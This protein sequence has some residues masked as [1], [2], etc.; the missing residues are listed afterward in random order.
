M[1]TGIPQSSLYSLILFLFYIAELHDL[2]DAPALNVSVISFVDDTQLLA[3]GNI[4]ESNC[5]RL[6]KIQDRCI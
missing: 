6:T 5:Q 2:C 4:E 1:I 3:F